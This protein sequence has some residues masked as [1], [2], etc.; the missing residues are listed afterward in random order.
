MVVTMPAIGAIGRTR[1]TV[2]FGFTV[3]L[4]EALAV[5]HSHYDPDREGAAAEAEAE[6]LVVLIAIIAAGE[7]VE[8]DDVAPQAETERAA[9]DRHRLERR[10][11]D[12]VVVE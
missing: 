2:E 3:S 10:G 8:R 4:D 9:E 5:D 1:Q 11:A 7:F 6:Q 12:A